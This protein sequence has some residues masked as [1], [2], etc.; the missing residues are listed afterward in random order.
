MLMTPAS[1]QNFIETAWLGTGAPHMY[2][3]NWISLFL[4]FSFLLGFVYGHAE[5]DVEK[6]A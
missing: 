4:R 3:N 5:P 1:T 2:V 6:H